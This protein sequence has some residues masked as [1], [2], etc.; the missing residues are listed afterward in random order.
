[1]KKNEIFE[2]VKKND[3]KGIKLLHSKLMKK[4]DPQD[5][6]NGSFPQCFDAFNEEFETPAMTAIECGNLEALKALVECGSSV[7]IRDK[8]GLWP[9]GWACK[10]GKLELVSFM[11][12]LQNGENHPDITYNNGE[13]A[14]LLAA[15]GG[16][17]ECA[18]EVLKTLNA[19]KNARDKDGNNA[20]TIMAKN[21]Q[22]KSLEEL[23][24]ISINPC[25][26]NNQNKNVIDYLKENGMGDKKITSIFVAQ[27]KEIT[28]KKKNDAMNNALLTAI[29]DNDL[30]EVEKLLKEGSNP[31]FSSFINYFKRKSDF[32]LGL[33][34]AN[35]NVEMMKLLIKY[36]ADVNYVT[37]SGRGALLDAIIAN[38]PD[39]VDLLLENGAK[40]SNSK[41][42][43]QPINL[44]VENDYDQILNS[45]VKHGL[46]VNDCNNEFQGT[47]LFNWVV[48]ENSIKCAKLI[49]D[50]KL[51]DIHKLN[52]YN[53]NAL[54]EVSAS[55]NMD[56][57]KL[58]IDAGIDHK[59]KNKDNETPEDIAK[60]LKNDKMEKFF[61]NL[62]QKNRGNEI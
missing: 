28:E 6:V 4:I 18:F 34:A 44:I 32:P 49:I 11:V 55:K 17:H 2:L 54:H 22:Y 29:D 39:A 1:M 27:A 60:D 19:E 33:A 14:F 61:N 47:D 38:R 57:A 9:L 31:N 48:T 21:K 46:P 42:Y 7:Y 59:V 30:N 51:M 16:H 58:L 45:M 50:N 25:L 40:M 24:E 43:V 5:R 8:S 15:A 23:S 53:E 37:Q 10:E 35:G 52:S 3:V 62:N 56:M 12:S 13:T 20:L 26:K 36:N 41:F